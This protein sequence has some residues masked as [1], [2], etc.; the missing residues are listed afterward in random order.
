MRSPLTNTPLRLRSSSSR[1]PS[2]WWT[3]SAWRRDTVGS[4]KRTSAAR[5]RPIRVH[6]RVSGIVLSSSLS[7]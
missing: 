6:S 1:T 2:G 4:S 5:L 3:I 7:S